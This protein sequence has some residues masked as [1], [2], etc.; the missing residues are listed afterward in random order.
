MPLIGQYNL[1]VT[2]SLPVVQEVSVDREQDTEVTLAAYHPNRIIGILVI[3]AN[4]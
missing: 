1:L 4:L 3:H 2:I